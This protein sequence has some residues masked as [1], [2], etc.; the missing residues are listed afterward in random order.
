[1]IWLVAADG[2]PDVLW[3]KSCMQNEPEIVPTERKIEFINKLSDTGLSVVEATSFVS[4]K[5]VPQV[6]PGTAFS[7]HVFSDTHLGEN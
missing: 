4:K 1:M 5:W 7:C 3:S 2:I 6:S